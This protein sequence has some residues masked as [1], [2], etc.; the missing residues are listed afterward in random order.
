MTEREK[1]IA[2]FN[3][4]VSAVQPDQLIPEHLRLVGNTLYISDHQV[5]LSTGPAIYVIGGG[6][7]SAGMARSVE[8]VLGKFLTAGIVVTKHDHRIPLEKIVCLEAGHPVPDMEGVAATKEIIGLVQQAKENDIII[9]LLSGGASSLLI[10]LPNGISLLDIQFLFQQL[11]KSGASIDEVNV[12]RKHLSEIKGGQLIRLA[13]KARW[14]SLIISDVPGDDPQVI[15]SGPTVP[16]NSCFAD[17]AGIL[18]K[19]NL[20]GKI[21][22]AI[23]QHLDNG[24]QQIIA[25]T[26]VAGDPIFR[27]VHH[28]IIGSNSIALEAAAAKA[29][30]FGLTLIHPVAAISGDAENV[31]YR[32]VNQLEQYSGSL[33]ACFLSG[34]ETTVVVSGNGKGGRNQHLALSALCALK[35]QNITILSAGTDGTDGPTDAAGAFADQ[36]VLNAAQALRLD[37]EAYLRNHDAYHFF[38][39]TGALLKTG[40]TQTNV[41]DLVIG[42]IN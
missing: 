13:P 17:V 4:A 33:P 9:C 22:A 35:A 5:D 28:K 12:V 39:K 23:Q 3:A 1:A 26:P 27:Q 18:N 34:G 24:L 31:G 36:L 38:E 16:D 19:Y 11:L 8:L 40:A 42:I 29:I 20:H 30:G 25:D 21:P 41:M 10:D 37:P 15:A 14:Y 2:I 32:L 7:A 6:K